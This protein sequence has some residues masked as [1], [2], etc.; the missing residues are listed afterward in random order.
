MMPEE[1]LYT[2]KV[3]LFLNTGTAETPTWKR[4]GKGVTALNINYN[5]QTTTEQYI[6]EDSATTSTDS[7]QVALDLPLTCYAGEPVFDHM[8]GIRQSRG[9]GTAA[10][11]DVLV[12]YI[13]DS[14]TGEGTT[15]YKAERNAANIAIND[16][17]GDAGA[18]VVLNSTLS[19]NGDPVRGTCVITAGAPVFTAAA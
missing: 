8:D 5:P 17:G 18:P 6:H 3:A 12:V 4:I 15:T 14:T 7:Y 19:F 11:A 9:V 10:S 2:P 13:Y 1:K 16:F